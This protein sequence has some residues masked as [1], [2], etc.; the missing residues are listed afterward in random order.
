MSG[1]RHVI[2]VDGFCGPGEYTGGEDGSPV[3]AAKR[4]SE[5]A[6]QFPGFKAT[7]FFIDQDQEVLAHLETL[8]SVAAPHQNV[9][10]NLLRGDFLGELDKILSYLKLHPRAP[11]F[12]FVDPF[13]FGQSP[14]EKLKLLMHN[15][16]SELFINFMCGFMNRFKDHHDED[17]RDKIREMIGIEDLSQFKSSSDPIGEMCRLFEINLRKLG[18]HTLKF[19]MRDEGNIR[20][21][22][23]FFCGRNALGFKKIKEAMWRIDPIHGSEFSAH[24]EQ[25]NDA[26][27]VTLFED[28]AYTAPLGRLLS[29]RFKGMKAVPTKTIFKW[30]NEETPTFL[31]R[32]ARSELEYLLER[33][34]IT[35]SDPSPTARKRQRFHWPDRLLVTF[36]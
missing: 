23:F 1:V 12:S 8:G 5:A 19:A 21:N 24:R 36:E 14:Y 9:S 2:Y 29:D 11:I 32:H 15:S 34:N 7:L 33:Q 3:L 31:D 25:K 22:A 26:R 13:G 27:Q 17:V 4:A 20:D 30:V 28:T 18:K 10:I 35:Y 16:S 6:E